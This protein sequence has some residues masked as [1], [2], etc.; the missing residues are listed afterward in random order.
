LQK[1]Y[2]YGS[3]FNMVSPSAVELS[4]GQINIDQYL[5]AALN[6]VAL[7]CQA[8]SS[9]QS[10]AA[11]HGQL[12]LK[13]RIEEFCF[14]RPEQVCTIDS[15]NK[16]LA[17]AAKDRGITYNVLH[18]LMPEDLPVVLRSHPADLHSLS[19]TLQLT[20]SEQLS[21]FRENADGS[22]IN[23]KFL[24]N[25]DSNI[26][27]IQLLKNPYL[28]RGLF[29]CRPTFVYDEPL[30]KELQSTES[31]DFQVE[32]RIH[33]DVPLPAELAGIR[34]L[35]L[36][37]F[38][39]EKKQQVGTFFAYEVDT[40]DLVSRRGMPLE[41]RWHLDGEFARLGRAIVGRT[42]D[43]ESGTTYLYD[44]SDSTRISPL[45]AFLNGGDI[46]L[47]RGILAWQLPRIASF[48]NEV[49]E[50]EWIPQGLTN[51]HQF[52]VLPPQDMIRPAINTQY[53]D[54]HPH[55]SS[56]ELEQLATEHGQSFSSMS[57][58]DKMR[59]FFRK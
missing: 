44:S 58:D 36:A 52:V 18:S 12:P 53:F 25:I 31:G 32:E 29:L 7:K 27:V 20:S 37:E 26:T 10:F 30:R 21:D 49:R 11:G 4:P 47:L 34:I 33:L 48:E 15:P 14:K 45:S 56:E 8:E 40:G 5:P 16:Y 28:Q 41:A 19:P 17:W 13:F 54:F 50:Q 3:I 55:A 39:R 1:Y 2:Y 51:T 24:D 22:D 38:A 42:V 35:N 59:M 46:S 9:L 6:D 23:Q 57:V 43:L